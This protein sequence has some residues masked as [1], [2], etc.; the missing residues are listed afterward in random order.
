[1]SGFIFDNQEHMRLLKEN[2]ARVE[3]LAKATGKSVTQI[4]DEERDARHDR[5]AKLLGTGKY[6]QE[7]IMLEHTI[8]FKYRVSLMDDLHEERAKGD[9]KYVSFLA[10]DVAQVVGSDVLRVIEITHLHVPLE[11]PR[12]STARALVRD[13]KTCF[14]DDAIVVAVEPEMTEHVVSTDTQYDTVMQTLDEFYT[15]LGFKDINS[16]V[17]YEGKVAYIL[18]NGKVGR[19]L[20]KVKANKPTDPLAPSSSFDRAAERRAARASVGF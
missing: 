15:Y 10:Q 19:V 3:A 7:G 2:M 12:Q 5:V 20:E 9:G 11:T 18:D 6:R 17:Q 14:P 8:T 1:M 13:L 16:W 4:L